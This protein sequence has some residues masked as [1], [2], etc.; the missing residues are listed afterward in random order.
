[1]MLTVLLI[2]NYKANFLNLLKNDIKEELKDKNLEI[3]V[4]EPVEIEENN[5]I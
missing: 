4:E 2:N 1:M 3:K 5:A